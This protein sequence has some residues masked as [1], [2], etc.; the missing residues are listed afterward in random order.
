MLADEG[1]TILKFY[2]NIDPEEQK[3]RLQARL[4]EPAKP[5]K[6]SPGD[7]E[8]RKLW[9]QYTQA[10]E[11]VL[12]ETSTDWAPWYIVPSN[13]KWYRNLLIASV[14]THKNSKS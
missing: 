2:L 13:R 7:L 11:D 9:P 4:D 8:E 5:W 12:S 6:F 1:T 14:I 10:Y 3:A